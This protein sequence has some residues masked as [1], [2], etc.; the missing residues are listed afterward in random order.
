MAFIG[1]IEDDQATGRARELFDAELAKDGHVWNLTRLLAMR[2]GVLDAWRGLIGAIRTT[3]DLRRY[4][5][6]TF[7]AARALRASYCLLAHG[8]ILR[9]Q[10][11]DADRVA[12][13]ARD[14]APAGL[15]P[16]AV[17]MMEF[18]AKIATEADR[19]TQADVDRLRAFG[20]SDPEVLDIT[21]AAAAR[22]F[23]TKVLDGLGVQPDAS[24]QALPAE[25]RSAL[26]M[27]RPIAEAA[28][29]PGPT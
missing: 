1:V 25:L 21:L 23:F 24:Y 11:L 5:L 18:A 8:S 6:V 4:E 17:A 19:V 12:A 13:L 27:G 15:P 26:T 10:V 3:L 7:A 29:P 16:A 9:D 22:A 2:P 20:F 28:R 14:P